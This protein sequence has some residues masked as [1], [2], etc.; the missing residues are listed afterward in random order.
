MWEKE[1][2][3][4]KGRGGGGKGCR[5]KKNTVMHNERYLYKTL[6]YKSNNCEIQGFHRFVAS[7]VSRFE[8]FKPANQRNI[9]EDA[10]SYLFHIGI[11]ARFSSGMC[12]LFLYMVAVCML[13]QMA[14]NNRLT[15]KYETLRSETGVAF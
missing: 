2:P 9:P 4:A 3:A 11:S 6:N 10:S 15:H 14:P 13:Q 12:L 1:R 8:E 7:L 5:E